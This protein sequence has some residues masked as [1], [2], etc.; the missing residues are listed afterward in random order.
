MLAVSSNK[1][2]ACMQACAHAWNW[3]MT[4]V[5]EEGYRSFRKLWLH[6]EGSFNGVIMMRVKKYFYC[7]L[8]FRLLTF[9][10][11]YSRERDY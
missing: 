10:C 2:G 7:L 11:G 5:N 3:L 8:I 4:K 9:S 6:G 1:R